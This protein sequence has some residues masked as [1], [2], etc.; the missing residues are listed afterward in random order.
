MQRPSISPIEQKWKTHQCHQQTSPA[1][2][3]LLT[4]FGLQWTLLMGQ[5]FHSCCFLIVLLCILL[6]V[7][8]WLSPACR[9]FTGEKNDLSNFV[10]ALIATGSTVLNL[11]RIR[12]FFPFSFFF[13]FLQGK[14]ARTVEMLHQMVILFFWPDHTSAPL[15]EPVAVT[16][17]GPQVAK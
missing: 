1:G 5:G 8:V 9:I 7:K 11:K 6:L 13:V 17:A 2:P 16:K 14:A 4:G 12:F 10:L 3:V 15:T